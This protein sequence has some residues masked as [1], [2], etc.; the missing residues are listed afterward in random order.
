M[1]STRALIALYSLLPLS[2]S[3]EYSLLY[4]YIIKLQE[5]GSSVC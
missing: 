2:G 5:K 4:I 1:I 3:K